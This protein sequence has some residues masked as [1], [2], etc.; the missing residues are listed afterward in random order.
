MRKILLH[1]YNSIVSMDLAK[2]LRDYEIIRNKDG[3]SYLIGLLAV[4]KFDL[5]IV[6][7]KEPDD[8][9]PLA[10]IQNKFDIP[11]VI[12]TTLDPDHLKVVEEYACQVVC[13]PFDSEEVVHAVKKCIGDL[14]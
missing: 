1:E 4:E 2:I 3:Y 9:F 5:L 10:I 14:N 13:Y 11:S 7:I 6:N 12:L 8:V